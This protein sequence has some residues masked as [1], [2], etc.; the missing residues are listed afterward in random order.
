MQHTDIEIIKD[1]AIKL[2]YTK[3]KPIKDSREPLI[4]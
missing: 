2:I 1:I 3:P 4:N